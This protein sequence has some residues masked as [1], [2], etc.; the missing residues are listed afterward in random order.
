[1][2][3]NLLDDLV[4]CKEAGEVTQMLQ[5]SGGDLSVEQVGE[6]GAQRFVGVHREGEVAAG[7]SD[8]R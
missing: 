7:P 3:T 1:M 4:G 2:S 8:A 5:K 6:L